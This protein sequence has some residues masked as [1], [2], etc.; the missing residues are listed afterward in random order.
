TVSPRL[1]ITT[2]P[3]A[4]SRTVLMHDRVAHD[5]RKKDEE[6]RLP[7]AAAPEPPNEPRV[8]AA[9][10]PTLGNIRVQRRQLQADVRRHRSSSARDAPLPQSPVSQGLGS[11]QQRSLSQ[12][13]T[14]MRGSP[15]VTRTRLHAPPRSNQ[16]QPTPRRC[17][18]RAGRS[19]SPP[20]PTGSK[21]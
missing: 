12:R 16:S 14:T 21:S 3:P 6:N 11:T 20:L 18:P 13:G 10:V 5:R 7:H 2:A 9:D 4:S 1:K 19:K 17:R 8:A 15:R